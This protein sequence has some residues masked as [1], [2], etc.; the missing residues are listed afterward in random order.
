MQSRLDEA[1]RFLQY[2]EGNIVKCLF[3]STSSSINLVRYEEFNWVV[4]PT[5]P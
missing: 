1:T 3:L 5:T 4:C 2:L